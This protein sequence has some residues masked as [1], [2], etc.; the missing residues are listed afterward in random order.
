MSDAA[1]TGGYAPGL[2]AG[3][4]RRRSAGNF[5]LLF[6]HKEYEIGVIVSAI[7]VRNSCIS[8]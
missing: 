7:Y 3:A 5:G 6:T 8:Q 4:L 2:L 1:Q